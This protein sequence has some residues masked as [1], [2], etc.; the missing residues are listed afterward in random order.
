[1]PIIWS[2]FIEIF[3][4]DPFFAES[5][6]NITD[7]TLDEYFKLGFIIW[8]FTSKDEYTTINLK[9]LMNA[10]YPAKTDDFLTEDKLNSFLKLTSA[11]YETIRYEAKNVN[12]LILPK[13]DKYEYN[14]LVKYPIVVGDK[15]F[16]YYNSFQIVVPNVFLLLDRIARGI[17]WDLRA[18]FAEKE[19]NDF[20]IKFG[21]SFE[22]YCGS[23]LS[24][25]FGNDNVI[26][27][28]D[29]IGERYKNE[30][31]SDWVVLE[32]NSI[33]IFE[34]KSALLPIIARRTFI[35]S[36]LSSWVRRNLIHAIA[37]LDITA[38]DLIE[39]G[40]IGNKTLN[41]FILLL[42][43]LYIADDPFIKQSI[44]GENTVFGQTSYSDVHII[45][46]YEMEK[47]EQH[48]RNNSF[49]GILAKKQELD[50]TH[51]GNFLV[52]CTSLDNDVVMTNEY[53]EAKFENIF[54]E[55]GIH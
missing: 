27:V 32:G 28:K 5:F 38:S 10:K 20:L 14:P 22:K 3:N 42:E 30:R 24:R 52:A 45:S 19:S 16:S 13:Y 51:D 34:C 37:Q 33:F 39:I 36:T 26:Q 35:P 12:T 47:M 48:I 6:Y 1:M 53:L 11:T 17:Y 7:L 54:K 29:I 15:R 41:K 43:E 21:D 46:I 4:N 8:V 31:H 49:A 55:W 50:E 2:R 44:I 23:L 40:F 18:Y 9:E 25:Y